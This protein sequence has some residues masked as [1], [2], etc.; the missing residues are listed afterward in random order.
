MTEKLLTLELH[1]ATV[2]KLRQ[3]LLVIDMH[4]KRTSYL[5]IVESSKQYIYDIQSLFFMWRLK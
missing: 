4:K 3:L 1:L 5:R 2:E